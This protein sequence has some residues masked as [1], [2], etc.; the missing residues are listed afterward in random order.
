VPGAALLLTEPGRAARQVAL[1]G[2]PT[3]VGRGSDCQIVLA[4]AHASRHHARLEVRG[5]VLVLTDLDSTN[6]TR[7]NGRRVREIV[8][9]V[10]DRIDIGQTAVRVVPAE[11]SEG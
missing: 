10:G 5:G 6:G 11:P 9:G 1:T 8:L 7:V 4:D 2:G 3:T